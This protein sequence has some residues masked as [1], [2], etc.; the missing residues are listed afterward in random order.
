MELT[1]HETL[2][3]FIFLKDTGKHWAV[4]TLLKAEKEATQISKLNIKT[5]LDLHGLLLSSTVPN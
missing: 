2:K 3:K 1:F 5:Q 4:D